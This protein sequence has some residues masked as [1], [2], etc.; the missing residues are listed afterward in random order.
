MIWLDITDPK[1]VLFFRTLLPKLNILDEI[2]ITTRASSDYDECVRLLELFAIPHHCIGNYGGASKDGKFYARLQRQ[3]MFLRLFGDELPTLLI[4]GASADAVQF[5]F[6]LG[7]PIVHFADTPIAGHTCEAHLLTKL[8]RLTLPLSSLIFYPFVLP[9]ECF[10]LLGMSAENLISYPFIDVALWLQDMP[11]GRDFRQILSLPTHRP[12][13]LVREEEYK[14]H[15][16]ARKLP[17]IYESIPLLAQNLD[18]NIV[19]MPRYGSE[20]L[21]REFGGLDNVYIARQKFAPKDF[22]PFVDVLVG[23]GGTMNLESC[24][25]G[26]PTIS[27]RSLLLFHDK[28]LL[29]HRLM[30]HATSAQEVLALTRQALQNPSPKTRQD[31]LFFRA[32]KEQAIGNIITE[33]KQRFYQQRF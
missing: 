19:I 6:G 28:Y 4:T 27:T 15:Y 31:S 1:Y 20:E 12:T 18:T 26:I 5:A 25:L 21:E 7:I 29:R 33:L 9:Q 3:E 10:K 23:G 8:A 13:I 16:V 30:T 11:Q 17:V 32:P 22:Y 24:Y 14:A 2:L